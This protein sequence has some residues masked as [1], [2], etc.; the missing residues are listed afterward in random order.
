MAFSTRPVE[1]PDYIFPIRLKAKQTTQL[2]GFMQGEILRYSFSLSTPELVSATYRHTLIRD[3]SFF[4][5][6][7]TLVIVCLII[8]IATKYRSY[9]SF[10]MFTLAFGAW[11]FRVL[12]I[13]NLLAKLSTL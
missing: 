3:M 4:G 10:A 2:S 8:F 7:A 12:W 5:S 1:S 11:M 9:L 6:M 13:R